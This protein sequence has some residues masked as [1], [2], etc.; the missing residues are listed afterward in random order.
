[1]RTSV[2]ASL[3]EAARYAAK[4]H[5]MKVSKQHRNR[6]PKGETERDDAREA[7]SAAS[8]SRGGSQGERASA[9][10]GAVKDAEP[11]REFQGSGMLNK[12]GRYGSSTSPQQLTGHD[13]EK[14]GGGSR[15]R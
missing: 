15:D 3:K 11:G 10:G 8:S 1:M 4:E 2:A 7:K 14:P 9:A 13:T 5:A 12:A 6:L